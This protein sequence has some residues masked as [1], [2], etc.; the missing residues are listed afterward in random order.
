MTSAVSEL[1]SHFER[2]NDEEQREAAREILRRTALADY[3]PLTDDQLTALADGGKKRKK[4]IRT[5]TYWTYPLYSACNT[6]Q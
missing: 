2:L 6:N 3:P 4:G 1:I 5:I